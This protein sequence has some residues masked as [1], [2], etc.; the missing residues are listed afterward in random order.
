MHQVLLL[1]LFLSFAPRALSYIEIYPPVEE[2]ATT[3][4]LFVSLIMSFG[5][6]FNSSH[7]VP[8]VQLALDLIN[9]DPRMLPGYTLH[10]TLTD[11]QVSREQC[12]IFSSD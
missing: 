4:P 11:S 2:N 3:K 6:G 7:S 12:G 8:G 1:L 9:Q 5:G 10:Y